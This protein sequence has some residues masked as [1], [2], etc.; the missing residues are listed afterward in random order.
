MNPV[1]MERRD[2]QGGIRRV[3][4]W[5]AAL[6]FI[7]VAAMTGHAV[8]MHA[9][10]SRLREAAQHRLDMVGT[11]LQGDLA[12]LDYLPS[13]L[14]MIPSVFELLASPGNASLRDEVNRY[15]QGVNATA[16]A[17]SLYVLSLAG[18]GVAASDWNEP[19]TPIGADLSFRPYVKDALVHGRGRFYGMGFTSKRAGYYLSYALYHH[20]RMSGIAAVKVDLEK[21]E[22]GWNKLPGSV[23]LV[24]Q[25][26]V[27][28]LSSRDEWNFRPLAPLTP[29]VRAEI[30]TT[31]P[32]GGAALVPLNWHVTQWL[33]PDTSLIRLGDGLMLETTRPLG[34]NGWRLI[35]LDD[36]APVLA[37]A[38]NLAVTAALGALVLLLLATTLVQ[39]QRA[40][41]HRLDGQAALQAAH[42]S[43]ESKVAERT[44]ELRS[45]VTQLG[46]EV[47]VRKAIEADLR[48][49]QTELVHAG[50]MAA[51]GQ[52]SAGM[53]HEL[54]QPLAAL[55]TLSDNACVLLEK[56]RLDDVRNNLQ[57]IAH[58][59][60]RLGRLTYQLKAFAHKS[61]PTR[62]PVPVNKIIG[63]AQSLVA[64]RL[65]D[66]NVELEVRVRPATLRALAEEARLE[67][68]LVNLLG[69][70]I[71]AMAASPRRHLHVEAGVADATGTRCVI[72]VSD[73]GPGIRADIL[74]R[75]FEPFTT[76]KMAGAGLGLGLMISAHIVRE[77]GGSLLG[78]NIDGGG[79]CFT[80]ELPLA[81]TTETNVDE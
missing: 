28:I 42:D 31:R 37:N 79:A 16:G 67:Q 17:S 49:T 1:R 76:S 50:K 13:L 41:R 5:C 36:I 6:L 25:R 73:T 21:T 70:A 74:P 54:N 61:S 81:A 77:L 14:E 55:R 30:A 65:L 58:L 11:G 71:D 3:L 56:T 47:E 8:G 43:L 39:R 46:D 7:G 34:Q 20:G 29:Q 40:L 33:A 80:I 18:V 19:G 9:G 32:Y 57:R 23:L 78:R 38:R 69:N 59:V 12:R 48:V 44:A 60:D 68:V 10:V 4:T 26:G 15:L 35:V 62:V 63:G 51:L 45:A 64:Q 75:L 66:N 22:R 53:V 52:M 72:E 2:E 27:V 24:D